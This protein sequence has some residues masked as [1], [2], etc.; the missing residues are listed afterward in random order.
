[1]IYDDIWGCPFFFGAPKKGYLIKWTHDDMPW[2]FGVIYVQS[3][4]F[5][6]QLGY[7]GN[8]G[9]DAKCTS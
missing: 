4:P 9:V 8:Q 2:T 6:L 5:Y 1:M 3:N 7:V